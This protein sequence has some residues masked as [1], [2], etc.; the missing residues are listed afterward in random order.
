MKKSHWGDKGSPGPERESK[1]VKI[2]DLMIHQVMTVTRHQTI[3][4]VRDLLSKH[5]IHS[6]PVIDNDWEPVGIV[7]S[8]DV[9]ESLADETLIGKVMTRKVYTVARYASPHIAARTMR[10]HHIH[11]LVVTHEQKIVGIV[12]SFDLLRLIEDKRFETKN[13]PST[14]NKAKW[15][16]MQE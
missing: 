5:S 1:L 13:L 10:K 6:L 4:H 8:S 3:G 2:E 16:R 9:I 12:S 7:T 11:H 14:P 15:E